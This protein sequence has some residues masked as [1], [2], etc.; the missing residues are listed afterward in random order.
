L[1]LQVTH[2]ALSPSNYDS[3]NGGN[4]KA[5]LNKSIISNN[6]KKWGL[7]MALINDTKLKYREFGVA[8]T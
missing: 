5:L 6:L 3:G 8:E 4:W 7:S 2:F 1:E